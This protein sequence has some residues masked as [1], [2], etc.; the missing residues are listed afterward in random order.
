MSGW[1]L[2]DRVEPALGRAKL[3]RLLLHGLR[4]TFGTLAVQAFPLTDVKAYMGH[5]DI[6]TTMLYVH[7]MP[8]ADAAEKLTRL[9]STVEALPSL[10]FRDTVGTKFAARRSRLTRDPAS[11]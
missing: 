1:R 3:K 9:V 11:S 5:A 10:Q 7:H 4:R 6:H 2:R 8:Q